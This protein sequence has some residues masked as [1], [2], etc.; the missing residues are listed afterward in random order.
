M[1]LVKWVGGAVVPIALLSA[2]AAVHREASLG[3]RAARAPTAVALELELYGGFAYLHQGGDAVVNVAYLRDNSGPGSECA[4]YPV[5]QLGVDLMVVSGTIVQPVPA[6]LNRMFEVSGTVMTF[7]GLASSTDPLSVTR[8]PRQ[9][10]P[11][12][13][14][15]PAAWYDLQWV[16]SISSGA[17]PAS[18]KSNWRDIVDGYVELQHGTLRAAHPSDV[19]ARDTI[20]EFRPRTQPAGSGFRQAMTDRTIFTAK[21]PADRVAIDLNMHNA[22]SPK[23][24]SP[25]LRIEV[26]PTAPKRPVRLKLIG[27]HSHATP[28][29][30]KPGEPVNHF[31]AFYALLERTPPITEAEQLIPHVYQIDASNHDNVG[32]PSPGPYCPG[33]WP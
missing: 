5:D 7:P 33:G 22:S 18:L 10:R 4:S 14:S 28:P 27:R 20:F 3:A 30:L 26:V 17:P 21:V 13:R 8:S 9:E 16:A 12:N 29:A 31:C 24:A 23:K 2:G 1:A 6:P 11:A 15:N 32:Q 19:V 25:V